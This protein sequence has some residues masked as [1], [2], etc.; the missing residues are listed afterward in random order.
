LLKLIHGVYELLM[1]LWRKFLNADIQEVCDLRHLES[2]RLYVP[3]GVPKSVLT[4][5]VHSAPI[6]QQAEKLSFARAERK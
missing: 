1:L 5:N 4:Q 2:I 3:L 6:T